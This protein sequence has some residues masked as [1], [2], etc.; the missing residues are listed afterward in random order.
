MQPKVWMG[1][2]PNMFSTLGKI[3]LILGKSK[4]GGGD[5]RAGLEF[6]IL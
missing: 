2:S 5:R 4:R 6:C 1:P 3:I